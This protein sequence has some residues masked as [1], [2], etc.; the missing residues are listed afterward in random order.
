MS[1]MAESTTSAA[2]AIRPIGTLARVVVGA[3][4]I[5]AAFFVDGGVVLPDSLGLA[6]VVVGLVIAPAVVTVVLASRGR[7][8][9][10]LRFDGALGH[11]LNIGVGVAFFV[12]ATNAA[13][14]FY[15]AAMLLAAVRGYAGCELFAV[16]NLVLGRDDQVVCPIFTPIDQYEEHKAGSTVGDSGAA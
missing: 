14:L 16:A 4:A 3:A 15:G 6:A 13:F 11:F 12:L 5:V 7:A 9:A 2:R 10:P 1:D 8:A